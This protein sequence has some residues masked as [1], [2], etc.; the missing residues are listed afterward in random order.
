MQ[1]SQQ[2]QSISS[3]SEMPKK[4]QLRGLY[5]KAT[6]SVKT[7]DKIIIVGVLAM[8][9]VL[10]MGMQ[11]RG[12]TV[13]F[14]TMGGTSLP[15]QPHMYGDYVDDPGIPTREGYVFDGWYADE[16]YRYL[17]VLDESQ[18]GETMTL[19]AKWAPVETGS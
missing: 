12:F 5:G 1:D 7:L 3:G 13:N 14:N 16:N 11:H 19:Y 2:T 10:F 17:W 6:I 9:I 4:P 15:S 18:V 8:L